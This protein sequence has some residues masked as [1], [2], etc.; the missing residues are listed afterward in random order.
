VQLDL[1][2]IYI[3]MQN[4]D[5][6]G[7]ILAAQF[8]HENPRRQALLTRIDRLNEGGADLAALAMRIETNA[9]DLDAR[10]QMAQALALARDYRPALEHLLESVRRDRQW[11]D[12]AARAAM[13]DIFRLLDEEARHADLAREFR[14]L[15]ARALN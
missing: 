11:Q 14:G 15:L 7:V 8:C 10:Q 5:A 1:A 9:G 6:A 12:A 13:L 2:E 4:V 3:E